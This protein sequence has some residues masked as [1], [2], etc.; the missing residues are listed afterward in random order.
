MLI[1]KRLIINTKVNKN[2]RKYSLAALE[3]MTNQINSGDRNSNLGILGEID[4]TG[5]IAIDQVAFIYT[6]AVIKKEAVYVDIEV[7]KTIAG[8]N[9][10]RLIETEFMVF[11]PIGNAEVPDSIGIGQAMDML[12]I[13]QTVGEDYSLVTLNC[14]SESQDAVNL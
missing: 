12:S 5:I 4:P 6:N 9:L 8:K 7:L 1:T 2:N 11:R 3:A 10:K 14:I 13:P